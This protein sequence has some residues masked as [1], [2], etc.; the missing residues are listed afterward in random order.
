LQSD[1]A[2]LH[3]EYRTRSS[4]KGEAKQPARREKGSKREV[5]ITAAPPLPDRTATHEVDGTDKQ[6]ND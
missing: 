1:D 6:A 3:A 4:E 2:P 5:R